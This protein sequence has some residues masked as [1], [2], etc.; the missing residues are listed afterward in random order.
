MSAHIV[1]HNAV[2]TVKCS[3]VPP[4]YTWRGK[5]VKREI[6]LHFWLV[7]CQR[8]VLGFLGSAILGFSLYFV[9]MWNLGSMTSRDRQRCLFLERRRKS[10]AILECPARYF[11]WDASAK[12]F[13]LSKQ[14]SDS[15]RNKIVA[16]V[17]RRQET[18]FWTKLELRFEKCSPRKWI[19]IIK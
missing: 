5:R 12:F 2:G 8:N 17:C 1:L 3:S 9:H 7:K 15:G 19:I 18:C 11:N 13:L 14:R 6:H 16:P 4:F 10:D